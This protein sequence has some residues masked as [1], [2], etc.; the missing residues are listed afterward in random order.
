MAAHLQSR[1]LVGFGKRFI[2]QIRAGSSRDPSHSPSLAFR[3]AVHAS[4]Y[5]KNIDE[6]ILPTI[7]P[8]DV[9]QPESDKYWAP[10]PQTGVFGP[11]TDQDPA[12]GGE[13][14]F[15]STVNGGV[16][17]VL[18]LKAFFRSVEDLD[19]PIEE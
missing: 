8:D 16:D 9:V 15:H 7:V 19:K 11:A 6:Q 12:A 1:G 13:R 14:G 18:E 5:D 17:S 2:N 10:H 4:V 3:R